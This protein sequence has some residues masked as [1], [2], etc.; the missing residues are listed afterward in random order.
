MHSRATGMAIATMAAAALTAPLAGSAT[1]AQTQTADMPFA[2]ED[3]SYPNA[4]QILADKG[5][6]L[7][8]G[9]GNILLTDCD[10][11]AKQIRVLAVKD[12]SVNRQGTYCFESRAVNG[13]LTLEL[14]RVFA[15]DAADQPLDAEL[16]TADGTS[17]TVSIA[18]DG[19]ASVGEG[20]VG[21]SRSTL[22]EIRVTGPGDGAPA[23]S[24]PAAPLPFVAKIN[25]GEQTA[26]SGT[27]VSQRWVLAAAS[28]FSTDGKPAAGKPAVPTTVT[29]GRINL[30]QTSTG[31]V[32]T[33]VELIPHPNR[34]LVL[35]KLNTGVAGIEPVALA[36]TPVAADQDVTV[37]GFGR[38]RTTWVPDTLHADTFTATG[39]STANI[40]LTPSGDAGICQGDAGGPVL[41]T[42]GQTQEL[43]AITSKSWQGG[44]LGTP[45]GTR[46][47][48]IGTRVDDVRAWITGHVTPV[49]GDMTG[50]NKPDLVAIDDEGKLRLYPGTGTGALRAPVQ[51]GTG[52][53][54]GAQ[55]THRGDWTGDGMEDVVAVVGGELRVYP[56]RG[57]GSL[58]APVKIGSLPTTARIIGVGDTTRDGQ[59]D[60]AVAY[61]DKL[62]IYPGVVGATP[63]HGT[64][65]QIGTSGWNVMT[66]TA[67]GD[68]NKDGR[69]DLLARDT[70]N[71][72][73]YVYLGQPN[74]SF[75][76]RMEFGH[77]YTTAF[78]PLIAGAADANRDGIADM[79][80]TAGDGTLKFY[81][82]G[83][84]SHGPIDGPS[85][86][87]GTGGWGRIKSIS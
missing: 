44:C 24:D 41:R 72:V 54:G 63:K 19:F 68:A 85:I 53:W 8:R 73:L 87:V 39:D 58:A 76:G 14:D 83:S 36:S 80:A 28:C 70:R 60:L 79:W 82:G 35:V 86:Q 29:V 21:G 20:Q 47:G 11:S 69:P 51:I 43:V 37:A 32:R 65:V 1:A 4:A 16:T 75:S 74:G 34:D 45:A 66:L 15:I 10:P 48:A 2:F 56:N 22:I 84:D 71:G 9:D 78:R 64:P 40:T 55:V 33:A 61:D 30:T 25:A 81:K 67:P 52:G 38:T 77:G 13:R 18:K 62:W 3:G 26:C 12:E 50:D 7:V 17:K 49:A 46:T 23:S 57:D 27:L 6:K 31:A 5:I 59:P 42:N